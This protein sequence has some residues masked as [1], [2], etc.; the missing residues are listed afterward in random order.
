MNKNIIKYTWGVCI[1]ECAIVIAIFTKDTL[2]SQDYNGLIIIF[3][4]IYAT[5][6]SIIK[7]NEKEY[8]HY[9]DVFKK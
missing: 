3:G 9:W 4:F 2:M 7:Y 6:Y 5:R 8:P 1:I